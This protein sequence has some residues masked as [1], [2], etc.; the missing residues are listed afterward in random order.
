V[1]LI[2]VLT[3]LAVLLV[4]AGGCLALRRRPTVRRQAAT[5]EILDSPRRGHRGAHL[6]AA[7]DGEFD[8]VVH[9]DTRTGY[10]LRTGR[11]ILECSCR[12][13]RH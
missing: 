10:C 11:P 2:V 4:V 1:S 3:I 5:F 13:H 8:V 9:R 12:T 7:P 6:P